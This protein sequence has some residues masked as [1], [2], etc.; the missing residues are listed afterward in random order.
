MIQKLLTLMFLCLWVLM[1]GAAQ[2]QSIKDAFIAELAAE[3]YS[4]IHVSRTLLG[5]LRFVATGAA[6]TRELVVLPGN[7]AVLRDHTVPKDESAEGD[8]RTK[9]VTAAEEPVARTTEAPEKP[10]NP[11]PKGDKGK[12][13]SDGG[14]DRSRD[15]GSDDKGH[16]KGG[17]RGGR[18]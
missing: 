15:H 14:E 16:D 10:N 7:G 11:E 12:D 18:R 3:G 2:A 13:R 6:G 9:T 17:D 1:P 8:A 4:E 5:R